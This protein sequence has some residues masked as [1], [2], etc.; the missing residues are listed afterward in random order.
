MPPWSIQFIQG[1]HY[2]V[3]NRGV[4]RQLIFQNNNNYLYLLR[5]LKRIASE[6]GISIIAYALLPNH[7]HLLMRQDGE[8][9]A[10]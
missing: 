4:N 7:Y 2:H 1:G 8:V 10:G 3:Y 5:L 9:P 6:C